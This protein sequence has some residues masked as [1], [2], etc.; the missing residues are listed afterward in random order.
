[1]SSIDISEKS[2]FK[3]LNKNLRTFNYESERQQEGG[4]SGA[5][6]LAGTEKSEC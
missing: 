5:P 3:R 2:D 4:Q 1:M 6:I